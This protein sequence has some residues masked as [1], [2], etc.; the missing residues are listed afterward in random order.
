MDEDDG[1]DIEEDDVEDYFL[2]GVYEVLVVGLLVGG[3]DGGVVVVVELFL[4]V[5]FGDVGFDDVNL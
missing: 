4:F 1:V 5:G 3:V 2:Y